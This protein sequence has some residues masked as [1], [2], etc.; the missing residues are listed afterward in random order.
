MKA[1]ALSNRLATMV[2]LLRERA[3]RQPEKIAYRFLADDD[4]A[5]STQ[6]YAE[7]DRRATQ[8]GAFLSSRY[9]A[10]ERVLLLYPPGLDYIA[11]LFGCM[12]AGVIAVPAYPQSS[13]KMR[14]PDARLRT[15]AV[16]CEPIAALCP[17]ATMD[18]L[19]A[20]LASDPSLQR[21]QCHATDDLDP[22]WADAFKPLT[23]DASHVAFLQYT[24]GSTS[25]PRGVR[26][27]HGN[28]LHN[29]ALIRAACRHTEASAFVGWLPFYHDMGLIGNILQPLYLGS[30]STLMSPLAFLQKPVRWLSAITRYRAATSGG[31][32]FAYDYCVRRVTAEE[33]AAL[34]LRSWTLA[35]NG[36]EPIRAET[37]ERFIA[38]FQP[39]GFDPAAFY[40]VYGLAEA[41]LMV[42][43]ARR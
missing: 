4:A 37:Q 10:G 16:D 7:L 30:E 33:R 5:E 39:C 17:R 3:A 41:T 29:E 9:T 43:A 14:Q 11:A 40:P 13:A 34:D 26:V 18:M 19:A 28:L 23:L 21:I 8:I 38:A 6:T 15:M 1:F 42:S 24:S 31:P 20:A 27:T 2:H 32:N 35:F 12:Y 36:A 25:L 22:S